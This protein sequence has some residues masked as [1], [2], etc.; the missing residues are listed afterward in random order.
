MRVPVIVLLSLVASAACSAS[1]EPDGLSL[2][3]QVELYCH[4][5]TRDLDSAA[6]AYAKVAPLLDG[7]QLA[8][9]QRRRVIQ[10]LQFESIG[11]TYDA[12]AE[13]MM[14]I[15][16]RMQ[17]CLGVHKVADADTLSTRISVL[18]QKLREQDV[19]GTFSSDGSGSSSP[20][21]TAMLDAVR[22]DHISKHVEAAQLLDQ[23]A[24]L[25]RQIDAAP[26][27]D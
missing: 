13:K 19:D 27:K 7:N 21:A 20:Q 2:R 10:S 4:D 1:K 14:A 3:D 18:D 12:R 16:T 25:A 8:P 23:L 15:L 26:L 5:L 9:D 22:R 24:A 11:A 6:K 17:F